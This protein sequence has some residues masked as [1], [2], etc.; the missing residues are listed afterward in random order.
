MRLSTVR[1]SCASSLLFAPEPSVLA[2]RVA[3]FGRQIQKEQGQDT[4]GAYTYSNETAFVLMKR[5]RFHVKVG[6]VKVEGNFKKPY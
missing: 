6:T 1:Q 3:E 4:G 5:A 2:L